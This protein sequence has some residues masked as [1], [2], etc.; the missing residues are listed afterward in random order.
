M[1][2]FMKPVVVARIW[3]ASPITVHAVQLSLL[4]V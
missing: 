2:T 3:P 1:E 4:I